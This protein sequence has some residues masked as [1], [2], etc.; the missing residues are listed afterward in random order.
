VATHTINGTILALET[1]AL[2]AKFGLDTF[3]VLV[4]KGYIMEG[5]CPMHKNNITTIV[6]HTHRKKQRKCYQ[7]EYLVAQFQYNK[8]DGLCPKEKS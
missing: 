6:A 3:T 2:E 1:I 4:D 7:P 5:N 8:S